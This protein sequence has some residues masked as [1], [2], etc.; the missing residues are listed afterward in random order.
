M[1]GCAVAGVLGWRSPEGFLGAPLFASLL[2][3]L[4]EHVRYALVAPEEGRSDLVACNP[5]QIVENRGSKLQIVPIRIDYRM[6]QA[7]MKR[8]GFAIARHDKSP[9]PRHCP[10]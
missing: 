10:R 1:R 6:A 5:L 2:G 9:L 3:S 4:I 7:I 8:F